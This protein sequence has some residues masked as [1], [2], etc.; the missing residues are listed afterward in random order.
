VSVEEEGRS[1]ARRW[2]AADAFAGQGCAASLSETPVDPALAAWV[3]ATMPALAAPDH[4]PAAKHRGQG[5]AWVSST[6]MPLQERNG[7]GTAMGQAWVAPQQGCWVH[8]VGEANA[9][10]DEDSNQPCSCYV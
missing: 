1:V 10:H 3:Q 7:P 4:K 2:P 5:V 8:W 9:W 6:A